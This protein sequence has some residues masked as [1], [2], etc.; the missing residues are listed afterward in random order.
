MV[1]GVFYKRNGEWKFNAIGDPTADRKLEQTIQ[2][3]Q[4]NY[5]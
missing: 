1:M 3:V 5:L 2:T 4:M